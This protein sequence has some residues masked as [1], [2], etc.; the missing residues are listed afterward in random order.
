MTPEGRVKQKVRKALKELGKECWPFMP[1]QSGF[2]SPALDWLNCIR[3]TFVAIETKKP[4]GRLTPLQLSTRAALLDAGAVV[5]VVKDDNDIEMMKEI[6]SGLRGSIFG[7]AVFYPEAQRR[8]TQ[9]LRAFE[10]GE[11]AHPS[12]GGDH[13]APAKPSRRR[14]VTAAC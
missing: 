3:G 5:L 12:T 1:V 14:A 7:R 6:I 11:T 13:G 4:G 10:Q 8:Y 9:H 2:G